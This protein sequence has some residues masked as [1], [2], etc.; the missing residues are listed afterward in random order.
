MMASGSASGVS[1]RLRLSDLSDQQWRTLIRI[2]LITQ[3]KLTFEWLPATLFFQPMNEAKRKRAAY[4]ALTIVTE[5]VSPTPKEQNS[6]EEN[7]VFLRSNNMEMP[8][9]MLPSYMRQQETLLKAQHPQR[10]C[11]F[12]NHVAGLGCK[13]AASE[14][15]YA[16]VCILC[17]KNNHG[18]HMVTSAGMY[19]CQVHREYEEGMIILAKELLERDEDMAPGLYRSYRLMGGTTLEAEVYRIVSAAVDA[20]VIRYDRINNALLFN[21][22]SEAEIEQRLSKRTAPEQAIASPPWQHLPV[23]ASRLP[24]PSD[25]NS[26]ATPTPS[27]ASGGGDP[28]ERDNFEET[29]DGPDGRNGA[30]DG[31]DSDSE[32]EEDHTVYSVALPEDDDD[33]EGY[34]RTLFYTFDT[35]NR[36][37]VPNDSL[38]S[39][40]YKGEVEELGNRVAVAIKRFRLP[41]EKVSYKAAKKRFQTETR[42]LQDLIRNGVSC[43]V[44]IREVVPS[45]KFDGCKFGLMVMQRCSEGDLGVFIKGN[46]DSVNT[47]LIRDFSIQLVRAYR[48]IH[49][50][51][52]CH[53]DVKPANILIHK[54]RDYTYRLL[55]CDFAISHRVEGQLTSSVMP[56]AP[57]PTHVLGH[58]V[59]REGIWSAPEV[60]NKINNLSIERPT[61]SCDL[62]ALGNVLYF[63]GTKG[64]CLIRPQDLEGFQ[65]FTNKAAVEGVVRERLKLLI[66]SEPLLADLVQQLAMHD[67]LRRLQLSRAISHPAL[68][69]QD[70]IKA[71][72]TECWTN[73]KEKMVRELDKS[74]ALIIDN[75]GGTWVPK[76]ESVFP[77]IS[78]LKSWR[79]VKQL[80]DKG[81]GGFDTAGSLL[82]TFRNSIAHVDNLRFTHG[83]EPTH[84]IID[85]FVRTFPRLLIVLHEVMLQFG[86][87]EDSDINGLTYKKMT[88]QPAI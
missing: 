79:R 42:R 18:A 52:I 46:K 83:D 24:M 62:W 72:V 63:L 81:E 41:S 14:C 29:T 70:K 49:R 37:G 51:H 30:S 53:I 87:F 28:A 76:L 78:R 6:R 16:H 80:H 26:A 60:F 43:V 5:Y 34:S 10:V 50:D 22:T 2:S 36:L 75:D 65:G 33:E 84:R 69:T 27:A 47:Y 1:E 17:G 9:F 31:E 38:G 73:M 58:T 64:E 67:P 74:S 85:I 32:D 3:R 20:A 54:G 8:E 55:L 23:P 66:P 82:R 13:R 68:W 61:V 86:T 48:T 35:V 44:P 39:S 45:I 21:K 77:D 25:S 12:L 4:V 71:F 56:Q 11:M 15:Q 7:R 57:L 59:S 19:M 88:P 40:V